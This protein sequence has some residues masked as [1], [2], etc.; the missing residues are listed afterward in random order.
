MVVAGGKGWT[1]TD[2][3]LLSSTELLTSG[4]KSWTT[5]GPLPRTIAYLTTANMGS[6]IISIGCKLCNNKKV[7][8]SIIG[9]TDGS[10]NR[11][12]VLKFNGTWTEVGRMKNARYGAA[13][14]KIDM[15]IENHLNI[16][17]CN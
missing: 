1:G 2:E 17:D 3:Y 9:G 7:I 6:Y 13:A 5:G 10:N 12:E 4:A 14:T 16:T 15:D 8:F 11:G